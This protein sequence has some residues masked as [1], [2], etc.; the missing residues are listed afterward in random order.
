[1]YV[2]RMVGR[3]YPAHERPRCGV[4]HVQIVISNNN[5]LFLRPSDAYQHLKALALGGCLRGGL[6]VRIGFQLQFLPVKPPPREHQ[7]TLKAK[8]ELKRVVFAQRKG[9]YLYHISI[10]PVS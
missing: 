4:N 8:F 9:K 1:M 6:S 10:G 5:Q 7:R 2:G 3:E